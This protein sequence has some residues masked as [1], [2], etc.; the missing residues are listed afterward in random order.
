MKHL[1]HVMLRCFEKSNSAKDIASEICSA[2]ITGVMLRLLRPS[3]IGLR[4]L[5]LTIL[6]WKTKTAAVEQQR[7]M[8]IPYQGHTR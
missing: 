8:W 1:R 7:R 2:E 3:A 4:D 6:T 5:E